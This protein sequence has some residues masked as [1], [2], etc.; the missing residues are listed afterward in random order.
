MTPEET[1]R[2]AIELTQQSSVTN[3]L[4]EKAFAKFL[5]QYVSSWDYFK[6]NPQQVW[7]ERSL[8]DPYERYS[9]FAL[10]KGQRRKTIILTGHYD[11]V[12]TEHYGNLRPLACEVEKLLEA[13]MQELK[14]S[15]HN[16]QAL[17]D[18]ASGD[19]LPG[20]GIFDMKSGLAVGLA[21]LEAWS[22]LPEIPAN[23]LFIAVPDEEVASHGM[24]SVVQQL[25]EMCNKH[26]LNLELAINLDVSTEPAV[27]LG[28]VGKLLPFVLFVGCPSHVGAPF[29][30]VNPVLLASEFTCRIEANSEYGDKK[31]DPPA[32]PTV[33]YHR[34]NR[35]YYDVTTPHSVFC[36]INVL[37][38]QRSP[39]DVLESLCELAKE[40][41]ESSLKTLQERAKRN[42]QTLADYF[43][44][45]MTFA[46]LLERAK[47]ADPSQAEKILR[48]TSP[49][50]EEV[51]RCNDIAR[52]LVRLTDI[53]GPAAIVGFSPPY[54]SR[55]EFN[56]TR[57]GHILEAIKQELEQCRVQGHPIAAVRAFFDGISDMS[58]FN[59]VD[60][61]EPQQ[62]VVSQMPV[63][64]AVFASS[65]NCPIINIGPWGR[66]Y[67]QKL[68][69][70][71]APYAFEFL[72]Q[73]LW[74]VINRLSLHPERP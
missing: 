13:L 19:F 16:L 46:E 47:E 3:T 68:E 29:D 6:L 43:A 31:I 32:P 10:V 35:E 36:A 49:D 15:G 20:R 27:F 18:F 65:L 12:S 9:L 4:G 61:L 50:A 67:H 22:R 5:W 45:V 17:Q 69:R 40:S 14:T 28:S 42:S 8:N 64:Q 73:F 54:Y 62:F 51:L 11:T 34:D 71:H 52:A 37:T 48:E 60:S 55:V 74:S 1:K 7:L 41:L 66:D 56:H 21:I 39:Q 24:K 63:K 70:V 59:P 57:D 30:G 44:K 33:L 23:L 25:P 38:H 2:L 53:E 72:P 26:N 58:F